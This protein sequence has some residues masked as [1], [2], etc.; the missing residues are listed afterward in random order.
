M[1]SA[2]FSKRSTRLWITRTNVIMRLSTNSSE[3]RYSYILSLPFHAA[4]PCVPAETSRRQ[5][6]LR[7]MI[8]LLSIFYDQSFGSAT[9]FHHNLCLEHSER[10]EF[11]YAKRSS[12][13]VLHAKKNEIIRHSKKRTKQTSV[14]H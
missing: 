10:N 13:F 3:K 4:I 14:Q 8:S 6:S 7:K 1:T 2:L 11:H 9:R 12:G 5:L